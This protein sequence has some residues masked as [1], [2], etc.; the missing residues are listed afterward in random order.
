MKLPLLRWRLVS[1]LVW[2]LVL[3]GCAALQLTYNNAETLVRYFAWDYVEPDQQQAEALQE[4]VVRLHQWHRVNELPTYTAFMEDAGR[5]VA[6]GLNR[7]DVDWAISSM[8]TTYRRLSAKAADEVAPILVT[9]R[10]EQIETLEKRLAKDQA[11]YA[12][13]WLSG[14]AARR[15]RRATERMVERFEEWTGDLNES[16]RALIGIF[17]REHPRIAEIR[18]E[19]RKRWQREAVE[20]IRRFRKVDELA[21]R[22][23]KLFSEPDSARGELY[24]SETGRWENGVAN[25]ILEMERTLTEEQRARVQKRIAR[26]AEDFRALAR[27]ARKQPQ[28]AMPGS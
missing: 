19:D 15:E 8:R 3:Q 17:V 6:R 12:R 11:K 2:V 4:K 26:Y 20:D 1:I 9:L 22:L 23:S 27:S 10:P 16:Q 7:A 14:N 13:D 5:R 25:L 24:R 21:P 28:A 18:L